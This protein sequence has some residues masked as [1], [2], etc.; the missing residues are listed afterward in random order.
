MR[1]NIRKTAIILAVIFL[2]SVILLSGKPVSAD[3]S[4]NEIKQTY[5]GAD[6]NLEIRV[7]SELS[8]GVVK[9][10]PDVNVFLSVEIKTDIKEEIDFKWSIVS[11]SVGFSSNEFIN[12]DG[13]VSFKFERADNRPSDTAYSY[14]LLKPSKAG[15][16]VVRFSCSKASVDI[17]VVVFPREEPSI[18]S[19]EQISFFKAEITIE[20][21]TTDYD[22]YVIYRRE[23]GGKP[24]EAAV[25]NGGNNSKCEVDIPHWGSK[26][27]F[28][29]YGY[30]N[31]E[32]KPAVNA[33]YPLEEVDSYF[34]SKE[35]TSEDWGARVKSV[36]TVGPSDLQITWEKVDDAVSYDLYESKTGEF[37]EYVKIATIPSSEP[38]SYVRTVEKSITYNYYVVVHFSNGY[39]SKNSNRLSGF[40]PNEKLKKGSKDIT[41]VKVNNYAESNY[42]YST[43]KSNYLVDI[44]YPKKTRKL[45]IY[46]IDD[47]LNLKKLKVVKLEKFDLW[48]GFCKGTD[49]NFYVVYGYS[50]PAEKDD[51]T[52]IK[53]VQFNSKWKKQKTAIIKGSASNSFKGIHQPFRAGTVSMTMKDDT[54][55]IHTSRTM[56]K[57]SDGKNHQS[58]ISFEVNTKTMT[59]KTANYNYTSHSFNQFARYKDNDLYLVD[60]GDAYPRSIAVTRVTRYKTDNEKTEENDVF[61]FMG[62]IGENYTGTFIG[63]TEVGQHNILIAGTSV[64]HKNKVK[65]VTGYDYSLKK[66]VYLITVDRV[67]GKKTFKWLTTY[68]PRR[69]KV[70]VNNAKLVKICDSRFAILYSTQENKKETLHYLVVDE[71]GKVVYEKSYKDMHFSDSD[72]LL[73]AGGYIVWV[74]RFYKQDSSY[75]GKY[76][77]RLYRLPVV[78]GNK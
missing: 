77:Q 12:S 60:H 18:K 14:V 29:A 66:N 70:T 53:V 47:N 40:I 20:C 34:W 35:I 57:S 44:V 32:E 73:F 17:P 6:G 52:V 50:N 23:N 54:L 36:D 43:G 59:A 71:S 22:G 51:K 8:D 1:G 37:G 46:K 76:I 69:S 13:T 16:S 39:M 30:I 19:V 58:N 68:H 72:R 55:F 48:G 3:T 61:D 42:Y 24:E 78:T 5:Q 41:S 21:P 15:T 26:Y 67:T 49:G 64:P 25:I 74:E 11:G 27:Q 45:V 9:S 56:F 33:V 62:N 10:G 65:G 7:A 63:G 75:K 31:H 2:S 4:G 28:L 38:C